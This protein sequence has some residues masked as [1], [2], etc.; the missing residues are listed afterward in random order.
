MHTTSEQSSLIDIYAESCMEDMDLENELDVSTLTTSN[1]CLPIMIKVCIKEESS[2]D[3]LDQIDTFLDCRAMGNF[4]HPRL[5]QKMGLTTI[6]HDTPLS[7]QMVTGTCF[8]QV[9]R[10]VRVELTTRHGHSETILLNVAPVGTHNVILGLPWFRHHG[11]QMDWDNG[12]IVKWSPNCEGRCFAMIAGLETTPALFVQKL[13]PDAYLPVKGSSGS[14]GQDLHALTMGTIQPGERLLISTG[15]AIGIPGNTYACITPRSGLVL[16]NGITVGAG[17]VDSDYCGEIKILLFNHGTE[18]FEVTQGMRVAQLILENYSSLPIIQV[19]ILPETQRGDS[20]FGS[21]GLQ[22]MAEVF[23]VELGHANV[24]KIH[25]IEERYADLRRQIL[26]KY[27]DYLD[28]FNKELG[29]SRCPEH[30]LGYDFKIHLQE[31]A[32][33]P[34]PSRP[35]HLSQDK[36]RIM[37]EWLQGMEDVGMICQST[38][39]CP[40]AAPVFFVPKKDSTKRPVIDYRCLNDVVVQDSYPLPRIDQIMDQVKGSHIFSKFDM[41]SG[42]NQIRIR[43]GDKWLA[44]FITPEGLW[45]MNVMTFGHMNAPLVFQRFMDKMVYKQPELVSHLVRYLDD[46]NTHNRD[47]LEHIQ[48]NQNFMQRCWEAGIFLNPKK[49][50]FHKEKVDFLGVELSARGFEMEC[51]K[52]DTVW[53]WQPPQNVRR[54][55]EFIGFCNFY[56]WFVKGFAEVA[57]PLHDLTKKDQKWEWTPRH[58]HALQTLKDIICMTPVLAHAN[59]DARFQVETDASRYVYGAVL[60]QRVEGDDRQHP[61]AFFSKS[62]T[63]AE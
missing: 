33:P 60:S 9:T 24:K 45:E 11:V 62:M 35:Y 38:T 17:V 44:A 28:V 56:R 55:H 52:V 7:L 1:P 51:V 63:P 41:K 12:D 22:E 16:R 31:G 49:C 19:D 15:I 30:Q 21:T 53:D 13:C 29:M 42:Y 8:H 2:G 34:P 20:G 5:V 61:V 4:I 25:P 27:H 43:E 58:Q 32:K 39:R 23:A 40:T 3:I 47:T 48:T 57:R 6:L 14:A 26:V 18:L 59:L 36:S 37:K 50:E 54:V 10:Q 46:A